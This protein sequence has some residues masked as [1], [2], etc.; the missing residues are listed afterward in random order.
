MVGERWPTDSIRSSSPLLLAS[1]LSNNFVLDIF[2]RPQ[3]K[4]GYGLSSISHMQDRLFYCI[5]RNKKMSVYSEEPARPDCYSARY[6]TFFYAAQLYTG[7]QHAKNCNQINSELYISWLLPVYSSIMILPI[8][9]L[10]V[11]HI[12]NA[13]ATTRES[14]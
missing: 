9:E 13:H 10:L 6:F 12:L 4:K 14:V 1:L 2:R 7:Q 8:L 11:L 5:D 3:K